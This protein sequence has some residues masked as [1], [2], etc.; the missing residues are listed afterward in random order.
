MSVICDCFWGSV[1]SGRTR[2]LPW[3]Q[4]RWSHVVSYAACVAE[5]MHIGKR[6]SSTRILHAAAG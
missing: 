1:A 3:H 6:E 2:S 4:L 5:K